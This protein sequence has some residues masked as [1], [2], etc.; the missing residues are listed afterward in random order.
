MSFPY[1]HRD[2]FGSFGAG[3]DS[4]SLSSSRRN[5][6]AFGFDL[7]SGDIQQQ[8]QQQQQQQV[9]LPRHSVALATS[10]RTA[11]SQSLLN[12]SFGQSFLGETSQGIDN[13]SMEQ[14]PQQQ[15]QQSLDAA[16][17]IKLEAQKV[18]AALFFGAPL[19]DSE[20]SPTIYG[21]SGLAGG[22]DLQQKA[23]LESTNSRPSDFSLGLASAPLNLQTLPSTSLPA[24]NGGSLSFHDY[25]NLSSIDSF[26]QLELQ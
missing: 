19:P 18:A 5:S 16:S 20:S 25:N 7:S 13:L 2:S 24:S 10:S 22:G 3:E 8:Q 9:Q 26:S 15:Q 23:Q 11:A 14:G 4:M 21:S 6:L 12:S 17:K 1:P